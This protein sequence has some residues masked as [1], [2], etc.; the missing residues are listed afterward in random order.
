MPISTQCRLN[1]PKP[2]SPLGAPS[3]DSPAAAA[4]P[5][6]FTRGQSSPMPSMLLALLATLTAHAAGQIFDAE[7]PEPQ[8]LDPQVGRLLQAASTS[9]DSIVFLTASPS[10]GPGTTLCTNTC[11]RPQVRW[12]R[13]RDHTDHAICLPPPFLLMPFLFLLVCCRTATATMAAPAR[14]TRCAPSARIARIAAP[15]GSATQSS[16]R[17]RRP[18]S[19]RRPSRSR[20]SPATRP[21][22]RTASRCATTTAGTATGT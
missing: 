22:S 14:S 9:N 21:P 1:L 18:R 3:P 4:I 19:T 13:S 11:S 2:A 17:R 12:A 10:P 7:A 5:L 20:W 15:A 16:R 8:P 6:G